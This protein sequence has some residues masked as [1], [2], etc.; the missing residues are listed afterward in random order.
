[1]NQSFLEMLLLYL[2][3]ARSMCVLCSG[4]TSV[5]NKKSFRCVTTH[6]LLQ[7]IL[8][9]VLHLGVRAEQFCY[10]ILIVLHLACFHL[11]DLSFLCKRTK[12]G[13]KINYLLINAL[14]TACKRSLKESLYRN[15]SDDSMVVLWTLL[16]FD[17]LLG[18]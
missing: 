7:Y 9:M 8:F 13:T 15:R 10:Y 11:S 17:N 3:L 14:F 5:V 2:Y 4:C 1:M 12:W 16:V 18:P 6:D